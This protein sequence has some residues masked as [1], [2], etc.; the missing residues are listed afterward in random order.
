VRDAGGKPTTV[1]PEP[2][3]PGLFEAFGVE[4]ELMIVDAD[5]LDVRPVCDELMATVAGEPVSEVELGEIAWSNELTLHV[6]ELKTN[7]PAPRLRGLAGAFHEH[8]LRANAA[9]AGLGCR[10][11]PGAMHPW[12]DPATETKL[13][14]HEY[15]DVYRTFDRIFGCSGHGWSN[16]QSTHLNL[17]FSDDEEFAR[18]HAAVRIVLP[19][20]PGLSAASPFLDGARGP[21]LDTRMAVYSTNARRVPSVAGSVIPEPVFSQG[22]YEREILGRIYTDLAPHD[23]E[24]V[25]RHEWVNARGAIARFDRGAVEIRVIDAQECPAADLAVV[26]AVSAVVRSLA[27]GRLSHREVGDDPPTESLAALF[28]AAVKRG[29][30]AVVSDPGVL[31]VLGLPPE[32]AELGAVWRRLLDGDPPPDPDP[33]WAPALET[34]LSRGP[35]ARRMMDLAGPAPGRQDLHRVARTLCGCLDENVLLP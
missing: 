5:T 2:G 28:R 34:I 6:L 26:A 33:V 30:R 14:P 20:I 23:P 21:A 1:L 35:L 24:G 27:E 4:I 7:G 13:W 15:S 31:A 32:P 11:L 22:E 9:L 12:M 17:P 25:L 29:D 3:R 16:L 18:L 10:L 19:L 8:A